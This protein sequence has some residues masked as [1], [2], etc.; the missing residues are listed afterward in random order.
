MLMV[1]KW[2]FFSLRSGC[3]VTDG[4]GMVE[5]M[6]EVGCSSV[7]DVVNVLLLLMVL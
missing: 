7:A 3:V 1:L 2:L 6:L 4:P 5:F